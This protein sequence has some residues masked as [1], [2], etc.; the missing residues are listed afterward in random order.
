MIKKILSV[1]LLALLISQP[2]RAQQKSENDDFSYALKLYNEKFYDLAA[3]QFS[4]FVNNYPASNMRPEAGYYTGMSFYELADYENAR[5]EFQSVAVD[6][7]N[8]KRAADSWYKIG[9]CYLQMNN[10]AEAAR[11]F[12]TVKIL[13][14]AH[15]MAAESTLRAGELYQQIKQYEKAEQLYTLIQNRYL[16]SSAYFPAV[17]AHASL[18]IDRTLYGRAEDKLK[19]VIESSSDAVLIARAHYLAGELNSRKGFLTKASSHLDQIVKKYPSSEYYVPASL[20]LARILMQENNYSGARSIL[21]DAQKKASSPKHKYLLSEKLGDTYYLPGQFAL[22][23]NNYEASAADD[24]DSLFVVRKLKSALAWKKQGNTGKVIDVL[25]DLV[26]DQKFQPYPGYPEVKQFY[27]DQ[28]LEKK[29][30]AAGVSQLYKLR[31]ISDFSSGDKALLA[32]FLQYSGDWAAVIKELEP[33]IYSEGG[34]P[35]KDDF[36][37]QVALAYHKLGKSEESARYYNKMLREF[38]PSELS[39]EAR[40]RLTNLEN[41]FLIDQSIGINQLTMLLGDIISQKD[42]GEMQYK[43]A[44]IYYQNLKD[45]P[46]ALAQFQAALNLPSNAGR[47]GDIHYYIGMCYRRLGEREGLKES[48]IK[49]Y[50]A[51][52]KESLSLAMENI[53]TASEPDLVSWEFVSLGIQVDDPT[54]DKQSGYYR[55]LIGKYPKSNYRENWHA[56]I[57]RLAEQNDSTLVNGLEQY[58]IL[59]EQFKSS[60][61]Y[62]EYLYKFADLNERTGHAATGDEY[63]LIASSYPSSAYAAQAMFK[64]AMLTEKEKRYSDANQLYDHL[65][66]EYYYTDIARMGSVR[67]ADVYLFSGQYQAA[68]DDYM[69]QVPSFPMDDMVLNGSSLNTAGAVLQYKL[70]HAYYNLKDWSQAREYLTNYLVSNPGSALSDQANFMLGDIYL[71]LNDPSSAITSFKKVNQENA[72]LYAKSRQKIADIYFEGG[73]YPSASAE[74]FALAGLVSDTPQEIQAQAR[75]IIAQ[76][77]AGKLSDADKSIDRFENKFKDINTQLANFQYEMGEYYRINANFSQAIKKFERVIKSYSKTEYAD[78]AEYALALTYITQ[79]KQK[80]ALDLL[81]GFSQKYSESDK[82]GA[83]FNT[84]GSIYFRSE[85]YESAMTSF[86]RGL[87]RATDPVLRQQV[88]SNLIKAYTFVNFWDAALA[89]SRDYIESYPFAEDVVDKKILIGRAYVSLNQVDRAVEVLKETRL[90]ADSEREPEIQFYIGDSYFRGGQYENAIAEF[91]KIPLL[92]RKT[93]L[94]WEA[95]ALYYAGQS[96]EKLGRIDEAVRMYQEIVKRPGIDIVLKKD[97]QKRIEQISN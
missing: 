17:L 88:M 29:D 83:V 26:L 72:D 96:Y 65:I 7:P 93:K 75:G 50:L 77:R 81:T 67:R 36:I 27:F 39:E 47:L 13:H 19:K 56:E 49:D 9:E 31:L 37:M 30:Y 12:E 34:F 62:P 90:L 5:I 35:E 43:L 76:I 87:D 53:S 3:Q 2:L 94:Q 68:I 78:D 57:A 73:D 54:V 46:G 1:F 10:R 4:R 48:E 20:T 55:M 42:R 22:A 74:Y 25:R 40:I 58:R 14:P 82:L 70:G 69:S 66:K 23:I 59:T 38:A 91:V 11:A 8:H 24:S 41:Y 60:T 85:K 45:Y 64:L 86:K 33:G 44:R 32:R 89:L 79:N 92:S 71:T 6:F 80:E 61:R 97:A 15:N 52:S 21:I 63:R 84:L 18:D 16:E 51:R 95:S 28:L